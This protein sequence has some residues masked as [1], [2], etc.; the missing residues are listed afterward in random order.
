M[1]TRTIPV[2]ALVLLA[3]LPPAG[4]VA[5]T[6]SDDPASGQVLD[7]SQAVATDEVVISEGH[8]DLGPHF[9]DGAWTLM[10]HDDTAEPS[11]WR[12]LDKTV[13]RVSDAS[14]LP[15]PDDPAYAFLGVDPGADVHVLP[16]TQ[17][18][19]V[20]WMGWNTQDPAVMDSIDRGVTLGLGRVE[21]PGD[22]VVYLQSGSFE[23][24]D[25]LWDSR[26]AESQPLWVDVNTHTHANWVFTRPGVYLVEAAAT[27]ELIDGSTVTDTRVIHFAV[28]DET[29]TGDALVAALPTDGVADAAEEPVMPVQS[30]D[31]GIV[32][33]LVATIAV[34]AVALLAAAVILVARGRRAKARALAARPRS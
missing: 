25:P 7:E 14:I 22:L 13:M 12:H 19:G 1:R 9:V 3:L 15:V 21:G 2:A 8:A 31:E 20:T 29:N 10:V 5:S 17:A 28:G 32:P 18:P 34:V 6:V 26:T 24:P 33:V 30:A 16:Q 27:A 11:V 4:A 23:A